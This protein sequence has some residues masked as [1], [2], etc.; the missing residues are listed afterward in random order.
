MKKSAQKEIYSAF[1]HQKQVSEDPF[2]LLMS[3]SFAH[4]ERRPGAALFLQEHLRRPKKRQSPACV[5]PQD[6]ACI[7]ATIAQAISLTLPFLAS[8]F[9]KQERS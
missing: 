4:R 7:A 6:A 1:K 2:L 9:K 5:P 3:Y 8:M